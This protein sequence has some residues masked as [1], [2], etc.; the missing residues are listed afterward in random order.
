MRMPVW[1]ISRKT[2][3]PRSLRL[4]E[5]LLQ[6]LILL[7]GERAWKSLREARNV[8]AADQMG[9]F[10]KLFGPSQFVEDGAQS[11]EQ[12]DIGCGRERRRLR[13]QAGHPAEDVGITAQL[14]EGF[15]SG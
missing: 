3:P 9:E 8:L 6:E 4:E 7:C 14:V 5:L 12:V 2:L 11:D 15:T 1:R 10:R 13:A